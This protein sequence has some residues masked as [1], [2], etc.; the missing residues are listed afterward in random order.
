MGF[1]SVSEFDEWAR[2]IDA[3]EK[4][5]FSS[6]EVSLLKTLLGRR[7]ESSWDAVY[8]IGISGDDSDRHA[9]L[10]DLRSFA[11]GREGDQRLTAMMECWKAE[12]AGPLVTEIAQRPS[13]PLYEAARGVV[14]DSAVPGRR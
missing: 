8:L 4:R 1:Q 7:N 12:D 6:S 3:P 10:P 5:S 2:M 9:L 11:R 13:D 14:R